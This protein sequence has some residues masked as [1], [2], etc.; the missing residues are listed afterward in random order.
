[1]SERT[2]LTA[3]A[4]LKALDAARER[5]EQERRDR[6]AQFGIADD[7]LWPCSRLFHKHSSL[8]P[9]WKPAL[10]VE[11]VEQHTRNLAYKRYPGSP[12]VG[13][14]S[15][16]PLD[17]S[18][19]HAIVLRRSC[20]EFS[21]QP[22]ALTDLA[23]LLETGAGVTCNDEVPKRA[24]PSGGALYPVETYALAFAVDGL[25]AS[26]YHYVPLDHTIEQVRPLPGFE[27]AQ[28]FL[29]PGLYAARPP[30]ILA[31]SVVFERTQ[32]KYLERGYRFALLEAGHL[33]QNFLLIAAAAGLNAL[34]VG[35]FWDEPFNDVLGF[36]SKREAVVYSVLVGRPP[37]TGE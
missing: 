36:D 6:F 19:E 9:A 14:P 29:P 25:S 4:V 8:G 34:P 28:R 26:V 5:L 13:L 7:C 20:S 21:S 17:G 15:P 30:L 18:L 2:P 12:R 37:S 3:D 31:I 33:A 24:A 27:T 22:L 35:G 10:N 23:R 32:L 11:E 1:M 16:P